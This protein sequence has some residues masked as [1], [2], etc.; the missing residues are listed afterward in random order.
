MDRNNL[1]ELYYI[2]PI[3][4]VPSILVHGILSHKRAARLT[5]SSVAM[6]AIQDLRATKVVPG[7]RKLHEYANLYICARNPMLYKRLEMCNQICVLVV[8]PGVLDLDGA[9]VTDQNAAS[10]YARFEPALDGLRIVNQERT[11]AEDWRDS[12][13]IEYWRKKA[14]KCAEVLVLDR[15]P[16]QYVLGARVANSAAKAAFDSL[17]TH[18]TAHI[19]GHLFFL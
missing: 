1:T 12:N 3:D 17:G 16:P 19:D 14:A 6:P 5:H 18:L 10:N 9:V 8:S 11:F 4:N 2:A 15:V 13:L 7:G